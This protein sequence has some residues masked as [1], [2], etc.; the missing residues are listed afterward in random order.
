MSSRLLGHLAIAGEC[1]SSFPA[2]S[3]PQLFISHVR[4]KYDL[5]ETFYMDWRPFGPKWLHIA[6][7]ELVS[8]YVT[9]GQSMPKSPVSSEYLNKFLGYNSMVTHERERW[10]SLRSIFNPGFSAGHI[11]TLT[12]YIV[13][14]SLVFVDILREKARTN[15]HIELEEL[16]T[17][18]TIDIIGKVAL[19]SDFHSQKVLH[20]IVEAFRERV[21]MMP[22]AQDVFFW[23][24]IDLLRPYKLWVNNRQLEKAIEQELDRKIRL[25][26]QTPTFSTK[27]NRSVVDLALD[28]Y[29]KEAGVSSI[30]QIP[31][32]LRVDIIDQIKTF[33]FAGHD[34]TSS[35]FCYIMY[36]LHL[37]PRSFAKVKDELDNFLPGNVT[38]TSE[39]LRA[40][41]YVIN[42]LEYTNAVV[43]EALR[44]FPPAST[45]RSW[46]PAF[47]N[48][49]AF[50]VDRKTGIR[51]PLGEGCTV[52]PA[53][54][55]IHRNE[56]FFPEPTKFVPE[57]FIQSQTPYPDS[58]LFTP[59]GKDAWRPFEKGP[60][61]CI[62]QELAMVEIKIIIAL[63]VRDFDFIAEYPGEK[64][65]VRFFEEGQTP[66]NSWDERKAADGKR[67]G[68]RIEG[69]RMYQTLKGAA[70]PTGG[71]PGR[72]QLR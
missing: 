2:D 7:P 35:T 51:Y 43:R 57:R 36:L 26:V 30:S 59:A 11:M 6:D 21:L 29:Q 39:K 66:E 62:G 3:H 70:K 68:D 34:T 38:C 32:S 1:Q 58:E 56:R 12:D 23:Q 46:D 14:A 55:L 17:R 65:D 42:S 20:P 28:A 19:D 41:P 13:D 18:L 44:L 25:R 4:G 50:I 47:P 40:D 31:R 71:C 22:R 52:W 16:T 10:K 72:V 27:R 9:T 24:G 45:L 49:D 63:T 64:A 37:H 53:S 67:V 48:K 15:E 61:N 8:E 5:P 33:I 54:H 69:Y 60:R